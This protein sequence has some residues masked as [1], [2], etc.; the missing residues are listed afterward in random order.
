MPAAAWGRLRN[1]PCRRLSFEL[2]VGHAGV[3]WFGFGRNCV[4]A[5]WL[6]LRPSRVAAAWLGFGTCEARVVWCCCATGFG[7]GSQI[8]WGDR[9]DH[10]AI[11]GG[12]RSVE[13]VGSVGDSSS[14]DARCDHRRPR[15]RVQLVQAI[16]LLESAVRSHSFRPC[17]RGKWANWF[18]RTL[19]LGQA[20]HWS[21]TVA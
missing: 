20:S 17:S 3:D 12:G 1:Q 7:F 18:P 15:D 11:S 21:R 4:G 9:H 13:S 10:P 2:S 19:S 5:V 16:A 6:V 14:T 8:C